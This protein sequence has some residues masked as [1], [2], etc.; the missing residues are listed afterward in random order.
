MKMYDFVLNKLIQYVNKQNNLE[1]NYQEFEDV[2]EIMFNIVSKP[3][4]DMFTIKLTES[5]ITHW[6]I[7]DTTQYP[8]NKQGLNSLMQDIDD[9]VNRKV[10]VYT[11]NESQQRMNGYSWIEKEPISQ[12]PFLKHITTNV[13]DA[14]DQSIKR[15]TANNFLG[16]LNFSFVRAG[17]N[18]VV[19]NLENEKK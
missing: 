10:Q 14:N 1:Y 13:I 17:N 16:T 4:K 5:N 9:V 11:E 7:N 6:E 2:S 3:T 15:I 19:E 12:E 8:L 18:F